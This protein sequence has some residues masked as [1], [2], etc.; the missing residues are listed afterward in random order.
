MSPLA[1]PQGEKS[2]GSGGRQRQEG[3]G[4]QLRGRSASF[5]GRGAEQQRHQTLQKQRPK[6]QPDLL[7][8]VRGRSFRSG[9]G[10]ADG[11]ET[12][13]AELASVRRTPSKVLVS[14]AVQR[15]LWPLHVMA[16][17]GWSVADL[18]AAAVGLYVKEGRRPLLPSA[19]P[20]AFGLHYSQF[21]LESLDP[22]EKV[23]DLGSRSFFLCP[24]SYSAAAHAGSSS[25]SSAGASTVRD[26]REAPAAAG[27]PPAWLRYM[28]F[29]PTM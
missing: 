9:S 6:T 12:P 16:S 8:G 4:Q 28:P 19:D 25:C 18:V 24:R 14:V 13:K 26:D 7:A 21:C 1:P 23:M 29:W 2:S 5:H 20:S 10:S 11:A 22:R 3:V 17:A 27:E 15:S